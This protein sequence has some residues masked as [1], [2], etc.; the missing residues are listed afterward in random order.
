VKQKSN[1]IFL[2]RKIK[3]SWVLGSIYAHGI[4]TKTKTHGFETQKMIRTRV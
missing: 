3:W 1:V 2:R 4:K